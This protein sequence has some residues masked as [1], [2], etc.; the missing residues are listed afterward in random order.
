MNNRKVITII[1]GIMAVIMLLSL[2]LSLVGSLASAASSSEIQTQIDQLEDEKAKADAELA[3]LEAQLSTHLESMNDM[4]LQKNVIDQQISVL[5][6]QMSTVSQMLSAFN[7]LIADKQEELD[8]AEARLE[9][10]NEKYKLRIRVMEEK[11]GLSYWSVIFN[12]SSFSDLLDRL[13]MVNE[14]A[15]ADARRLEEL[16][17][18]ATLVE[19]TR[20]ELLTQKQE[21][22][23]TKRSLQEMR[24]EMLLKQAEANALLA[25]LVALGDEYLQYVEDAEDRQL[26]LML[27]L[28]QKGEEL[29][30][31]KYREWLAT[32]VPPTSTSTSGNHV[33]NTVNGI[34]WY[35]PTKNFV[36]TSLYGPR[37]HPITGQEGKMHWGVDMAA[38]TGTPIYATRSGIITAA[39]FQDGGAGY[40]VKINHG[41]GYGS[42]YMHMTHYIV[43]VGDYV[44]AGQIIGYVGSTGGSTGPHL[45]FG[46]SK[47]G[48]YVDPLDYIKT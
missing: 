23:Q 39:A 31:A 22:E 10:L 37:K 6:S 18:A 12:A 44:S 19:N 27:Q 36:I 2:V 7:L 48:Y 38:V 32:S 1:A 46:I 45:H 24:E 47:N 28:A 14:I 40:Y 42:I 16:R 29:D 43:S 11:G 26:A 25:E 41:D 8:R 4:I 30:E 21:M 13:N 5:N 34:T 33:T 17:E 9:E 3:A 20:A 15:Y 35:T